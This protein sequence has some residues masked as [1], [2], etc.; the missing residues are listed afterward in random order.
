MSNTDTI[1]SGQPIETVPDRLHWVDLAKASAIL[2]VVLFHSRHSTWLIGWSNDAAADQFWKVINEALNPI[3]MPTFFIVSGMLAAKSLWRPWEQVAVNRVWNNIY[4]YLIWAVI[5]AV[6]IPQWPKLLHPD[7][8]PPYQ[9]AQIIGG[10]T[11]AWYLWTLALFFVVARVTRSISGIWVL[12]TTA[13]I[14]LIA[15]DLPVYVHNPARLTAQCA[16]FFFIGARYP[17]VPATIASKATG[18]RLA[19]FAVLFALLFIPYYFRVPGVWPFV[20]TAA[21]CMC[22]T[23]AALAVRKSQ[24]VNMLSQWLG[25][26]TLQIYVMHFVALTFF[27][28]ALAWTIPKVIK[29]SPVLPM[30]SP[31]IIAAVVVT[32]CLIGGALL[33]KL[34]LGWL[35]EMPH[36]LRRM[37]ADRYTARQKVTT[38]I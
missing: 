34:R 10:D 15:L 14:A 23:A 29:A 30:F 33:P 11:P 20:G 3:R 9:A 1:I 8:S 16:L 26:R 2:L 4:V 38:S 35:L 6:L 27:L 18:T 22:I 36:G 7:Y 17:T 19:G 21:I 37:I 12:L 24:R 28:N 25:R 31:L 32:L 13:V 5:Y